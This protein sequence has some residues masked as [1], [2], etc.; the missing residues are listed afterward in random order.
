MQHLFQLMNSQLKFLFKNFLVSA[1]TLQMSTQN[2]QI[3]ILEKY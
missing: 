3:C 2:I 1:F